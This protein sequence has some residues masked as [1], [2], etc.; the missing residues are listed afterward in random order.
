MI[1]ALLF[2]KC[3]GRKSVFPTPLMDILSVHFEH[4]LRGERNMPVVFSVCV[5]STLWRVFNCPCT[6][7]NA[8]LPLWGVFIY[9]FL[10]DRTCYFGCLILICDAAEFVT[11]SQ[12]LIILVLFYQQSAIGSILS[13]QPEQLVEQ[14]HFI[15]LVN[16]FLFIYLIKVKHKVPAIRW[17]FKQLTSK[18]TCHKNS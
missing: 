10:N 14:M 8:V 18:I 1:W 17:L 5:C 9:L 13:T 16:V 7:R 15:Q 3:L 6:D 2:P 4:W 12:S 11:L